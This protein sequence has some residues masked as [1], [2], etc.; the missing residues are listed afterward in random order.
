MS[1]F[2]ELKRRKVFRVAVVSA[3]T[4]FVILQATDIMLPRLG[5]PNGP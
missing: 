2:A 1:L 5:V 4:A 3:A